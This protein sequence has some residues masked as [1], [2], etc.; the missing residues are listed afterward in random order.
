MKTRIWAWPIL[1]MVSPLFAQTDDLLFIHHS[2]GMH[3]LDHS[4]DSALQAKSYVDERNDSDYGTD[5]PNDAGRPD[6]LGTPGDAT[7]PHNW[8][9]WFNDYLNGV[10]ALGCADGINRIVIFKSCYPNSDIGAD[11]TEPGNPFSDTRTLANYRAVY[12]HPSGPGGLYTNWDDTVYA[13]LESVFAGNPD[14]L[15]IPVT[16]PPMALAGTVANAARARTFNTWLTNDWLTAYNTRHPGLNNVAV[17]DWFD[18]LANPASHATHANLLRED[19]GGSGDGHPNDTAHA[20]S[21]PLF[22]TDPANFIDAAW[23]AFSGGSADF[24]PPGPVTN[25][26]ATAS[27]GQVHLTWSNP[28]NDD[29]QATVVQRQTTGYP[30]S[31]GEGTRVYHGTGNSHTD[32]TVMA[33]MTYYYAAFA[34]D[35]ATHTNWSAAAESARDNATVPSGPVTGEVT[36]VFQDGAGSDPSYAGCEDTFIANFQSPYQN[37][38]ASHQVRLFRGDGDSQQYRILIR[39]DLS[40]IPDGAEVTAATLELHQERFGGDPPG[41]TVDAY[42][43]TR[44]WVEGTGTTQGESNR[45]G[46]SWEE[47]AAGTSW[48]TPGG[49]YD[50]TTDFGHGANGT[51]ART[52]LTT[53][54]NSWES[55]DVTRVVDGWVDGTHA[56]HGLILISTDGQYSEH[57][58][59]SADDATAATRPRMTVTYGGGGSTT[60]D[61]TPPGEVT[62]FAATAGASNISLA[63]TN[64]TDADFAGT[65]VMRRSDAYPAT[66]TDGTQ[67]YEGTGTQAVDN[68]VV[69][70]TTYYYAAFAFDASNNFASAGADARH[71]AQIGGGPG[72]GVPSGRVNPATDL[73][74]LGAFRLPGPTG[75]SSWE[76]G[77]RALAYYPDGDAGGDGDGYPGSLYGTGL[78]TTGL[79]CEVS[80]PAPV[81]SPTKNVADLNTAGTLQTW[82]LARAFNPAGAGEWL[83]CDLAWLPPQTGQTTPKL[84]QCWVRH[85][86]DEA[87]PVQLGWC[88]M[89]LTGAQGGWYLGTSDGAPHAEASGRYMCAIPEAWAAAHTPGRRLLVGRFREGGQRSQGPCFFAYGPW[90]HG[91]P[92][93]ANAEIG[94]VRLLQYDDVS[95][96]H[97]I[98]NY[99]HADEWVGVSWLT[100]SGG[101]S[102]VVLVGIKAIGECWY[103]YQVRG[104]PG[105]SSRG[106]WSTEARAVFLFYDPDELAD[107]AA[108]TSPAWSPQPYAVLDIDDVLYK[109]R[110]VNDRTRITACAFDRE[111]GFFYV[112]ERFAD[113]DQPIAH[114]WHLRERLSLRLGSFSAGAG[115]GLSLHGLNTNA[116]YDVQASSN[117]LGPDWQVIHTFSPTGATHRWSDPTTPTPPQRCYRLKRR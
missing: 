117:L 72:P 62:G 85:Q 29:W 114:V 4:L 35:D 18:V 96:S 80:I 112:L 24:T 3:W 90:Q 47:A 14:T 79:I 13:P 86:Q 93:A 116:T 110:L 23:A 15:F 87:K 25:M 94:Y 27:T 105:S 7:D 106:F 12:R 67:V 66:H 49:D 21:T 54:S 109:A 31:H 102:A 30:A 2:C 107:V 59:Y 101:K 77:G 39:F 111:R 10:K 53:A 5:V 81:D 41:H 57:Y 69:S 46:A 58:F 1:L 73:V 48:A 32:L 60:N 76:W 74:Y 88:E 75:A 99:L 91:N 37:M 97:T 100:G 45:L 78:D 36:V 56:N 51:V 40:D 34:Y 26:T 108:G 42:R 95:G 61:M 20:A 50:S 16:A 19:Y 64:P 115:A 28:T 113:G 8:I 52:D 89:D 71:L 82:T 63:W 22:A 103:G 17:F 83:Y 104:D 55:W 68:A 70:G 92:P 84:H 44:S 43:M 11:G 6:S 9:F 38:G 98:T 65:R 33:G